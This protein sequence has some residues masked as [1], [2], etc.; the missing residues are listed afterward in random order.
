VTNS[1]PKTPNER[2]IW[3]DIADDSAYVWLSGRWRCY[4][5]RG[6]EVDPYA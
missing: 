4:A 3:L 6:E 2:D 5:R 1:T